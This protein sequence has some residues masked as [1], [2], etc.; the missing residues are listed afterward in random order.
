MRASGPDAPVIGAEAERLIGRF[1]LGMVA[2]ADADGN[3]AVSPKG[4]FLVIDGGTVGFA[5][6]RSPGTM[7]RL[8]ARASTEVAFLDP[9]ARKAAR[10]RGTA[11]ARHRG[12]SEF[13]A[14]FPRW[15]AAW[16]D[17]APRVRAIV[18]IAVERAEIVTTPPYDDGATEE[19]LIAAYKARYEEYYP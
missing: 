11:T 16:P 5:H 17:L 7:A 12:D 2:T 6:I 3:P 15:E 18:T 8:A 19:E 9:F 4:T 13:D 14:L 1:P 10:L